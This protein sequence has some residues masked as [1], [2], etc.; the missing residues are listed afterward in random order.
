MKNGVCRMVG[1]VLLVMVVM[2]V[3]P[4]TSTTGKMDVEVQAS[5]LLTLQDLMAKFPAGFQ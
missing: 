1:F 4:L 2:G 5:E 3:V